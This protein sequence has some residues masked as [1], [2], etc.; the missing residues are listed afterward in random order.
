[1]QKII[2]IIFVAVLHL[3]WIF[4]A[5]RYYDTTYKKYLETHSNFDWAFVFKKRKLPYTENYDILFS[6]Q[7]IGTLTRRYS[8]SHKR[9]N[10]T[11]E[12]YVNNQ[13]RK[14]FNIPGGFTTIMLYNSIRLTPLCNIDNFNLTLSTKN[15]AYVSNCGS[16]N[17]LSI[18]GKRVNNVLQV[19]LDSKLFPMLITSKEIS[20]GINDEYLKNSFGQNFLLFGS[21]PAVGKSWTIKLGTLG[22]INAV[23]DE[24]LIKEDE[25]GKEIVVYSVSYSSDRPK[26]NGYSWINESGELLKLVMYKPDITI[27]K[28][29]LKF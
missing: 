6:G 29:G 12:A 1:M 23:V 7:K 16:N 21:R 4:S 24:K 28:K 10:I 2:L 20:L 11:M 3:L 25:D 14:L 17:I 5:K 26:I 13:N 22:E 27:V 15:C 18:T 9:F 19:K 8:K